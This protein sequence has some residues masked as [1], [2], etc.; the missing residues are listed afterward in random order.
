MTGPSAEEPGAPTHSGPGRTGANRA[1]LWKAAGSAAVACIGAWAA[2]EALAL[3]LYE[4]GAPAPGL[5]P[6]VF[7][8]LLV[9]IALL[10]LVIDILQALRRDS[11]AF[12]PERSDTRGGVRVFGYLA[13]GM[14]CAIAMNWIG[15]LPA[16]FLGILLLVRLVERMSWRASLLT[17]LG[18]AVAAD[19]L[20]VRLL[21]VPLP[22]VPL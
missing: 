11:E 15:F 17:A 1:N 2:L 14:V 6:F 3:G 22:A 8:V 9:A 21:S 20:F 4:F 7:G 18:S 5:F 12:V 16:A 19:L 10:S 13:V